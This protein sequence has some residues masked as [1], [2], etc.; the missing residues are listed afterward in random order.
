LE[1]ARDDFIAYRQNNS[2]DNPDDWLKE[3]YK[4]E[5]D[6]DKTKSKISFE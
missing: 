2:L 3:I 6:I 5:K 4:L 1:S